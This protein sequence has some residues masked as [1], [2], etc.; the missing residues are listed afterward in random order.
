[1]AIK[2]SELRAGDWVGLGFSFLGLWDGRSAQILDDADRN[3]R[4]VYIPGTG[5]VAVWIWE[6]E[7]PTIQLSESQIGTRVRG[8]DS[9]EDSRLNPMEVPHAG[10]DDTG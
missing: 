10:S 3:L 8:L 4:R 7:T 2:S 5:R 1:M 9:L 6:V